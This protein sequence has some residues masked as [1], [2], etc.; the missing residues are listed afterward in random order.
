MVNIAD[1]L[2][3][4]GSS[5][6][7]SDLVTALLSGLGPEFNSFVVAVTTRSDSLSS[8][9][10]LGYILAHEALLASQHTKLVQDSSQDPTALNV[11]KRKTR[12]NYPSS[13]HLR[14]P[15]Y[16]SPHPPLLPRPTYPSSTSNFHAAKGNSFISGQG[17]GYHPQYPSLHPSILKPTCQICF[18]RGH[19]ARE[20]YFR[21][22]HAYSNTPSTHQQAQALLAAPSASASAGWYLDSG[23]T[24][25]V[26]A[27]INNLSSFLPYNGTDQLQVGN[28]MT[29]SICNLGSGLLQTATRPLFLNHVLHVPAIR[30]NLISLS[31]LILDND[32]LIEFQFSTCIIKDRLTK[33]PILH[34]TLTN[35]L[36]LVTTAPQVFV[37]ERV[38]AD[39]W[40]ARLGHPSFPTTRLVLNS[41]N[42]PISS[43]T[44]SH[45]NDCNKAKAHVLPF[46]S[47]SSI[48]SSPLEVIHSDLWGPSP[49]VST[50]GFKYYV[51]F[52]DEYSHFSWIYFLHSKDELVKVFSLFKEQVENFLD[53]KIKILQSDGGTEYKPLTRLFPQ[54]IHQ[55]SCPYTPQQNGL[56]ERKHRHIVELSL[57]IMSHA[58]IPLHF[59]DHIFQSVVFLINRLPPS[60]SSATSSPYH[61]LYNSNPDYT[62]LRVLGCLCYPLLRPYNSHKL[63]FRSLP[64]IFLGYSTTQKGYKCYHIATNKIYMTRN[65]RF[66]EHIFPF[67]SVF[68]STGDSISAQH[69]QTATH[70]GLQSVS[71]SPL[72]A[73]SRP[74]SSACTM[75][76]PAIHSG[77]HST[78]YG[79]SHTTPSSPAVLAQSVPHSTHETAPTSQTS[80]Q[81]ISPTQSGLSPSTVSTTPINIPSHSMVTRHQD[82]TR[83]IKSFPDHVTYLTTKHPLPPIPDDYIEPTTFHQANKIPQWRAAMAQELNA[84]LLNK[85]WVLVPP[86]ADYNIIG[87]KWIYK[88]KRNSD[89][90][91]DRFKARL[92]AKGYNQAEGIDYE[93]TFS[94]VVKPTIIR[95]VLSLAVSHKWPIRQLDVNNAFL[96]GDLHEEV[97]MSQPLGF[98]DSTYPSH[99]CRLTKALYGLK[100]AP[101]AWF[102][103]LASSLLALGFIASTSDPSLFLC[104]TSTSL[105]IV[106]IYVDDILLTG[107]DSSFILQLISSLSTSFSLKDL[108]SL[109]YFLGVQVKSNNTDLHLSQPKYIRDILLR[110]KMDGAKPCSTPCISGK[111]LSKFQGTPMPDPQL[112]RSIVG[113]LQYATIIRPDISYAVN[114]ASQFMHAPTSDHWDAVKR[115]L[116]YLKG[117]IDHGLQLHSHSSLDLHVYSDADWAGCPD[118]RRSTSGYCIFLGA[119]LISWSSKK[120]HTV[121]RSSTEAEY[122]SM[123]MACSELTWIQQL[124]HELHH[125]ATS[126]P[127]LWCDNLG[128]TF[129]AANLVFHARTKHI[130]I[131]YHFVRER[132]ASKSLL[133]RFIYSNDQLADLLTKGLPAARLSFLRSKLT[134]LPGFACGGVLEDKVTTVVS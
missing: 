72:A 9:D 58:S 4:S 41:N 97:Y 40:H 133:V 79:P 47:S 55:T 85:I 90:S 3:A 69:P 56:A 102:H 89:G 100:Q 28:G 31:K 35:G 99:V 10:L 118:D 63:Q 132:V 126:P 98:I 25:H 94:P 83:K 103:K 115:I 50:T 129:L 37:G 121:S 125:T 111:P 75:S 32:I 84:L 78:N 5:V 68:S 52:I 76:S 15:P 104:H 42:L 8:S 2:S 64:C 59:W 117:T 87:C 124:L 43:S 101:R 86:S 131:D 67:S 54:I 22:D 71:S 26:T 11:V 113:A 18:K 53:K 27:D 81:P 106:L 65:V 120:Q 93:D 116:R 34:A 38:S 70:L 134:I 45:C 39:I 17:R 19:S 119:N 24:H 66:V 62:F 96:H 23:A 95:I 74:T 92:V 88:L 77:L 112:Y 29:L 123:A 130:E 20:C 108:G 44:L 73:P 60:H 91:I 49:V 107:S 109:H 82:N 1:Q 51:H 105:T 57:A 48:A 13:Q 33:I 7:D 80:T 128:A 114:K 61:L 110:A 46:H 6:S 14:R 36:Y 122:R 127:I 16:P 21:F 30:K 12:F